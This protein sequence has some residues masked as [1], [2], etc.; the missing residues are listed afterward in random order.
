MVGTLGVLP[1]SVHTV[2]TQVLTV[3]FMIPIG[4]GIAL[5]IRLGVTLPRNVKRAQQLVLGCG[6]ISIVLFAIMSVFLW[7]FR[8][9][10][11]RLFTTEQ[12]VREVRW[13]CC[14]LTA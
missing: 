8:G 12:D 13:H 3:S 10:I 2:P 11:F 5:S 9:T 14:Y 1:L 7:T 4:I 6:L